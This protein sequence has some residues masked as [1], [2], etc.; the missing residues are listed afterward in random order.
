MCS[1]VALYA[2]T[3]S[4]NRIIK[5][6]PPII[7]RPCYKLDKSRLWN[8]LPTDKMKLKLNH[9]RSCN[10][11]ICNKFS[12]VEIVQGFGKLLILAQRYEKKVIEKQ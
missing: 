5:Q 12:L 4:I 8:E 1:I 11:R 3:P 9:L 7:T 2:L 10:W 6:N